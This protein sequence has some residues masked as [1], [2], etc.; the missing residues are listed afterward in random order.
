[1]SK[2]FGQDSDGGEITLDNFR[3]DFGCESLVVAQIFKHHVWPLFLAIFMKAGCTAP[4][5]GVVSILGEPYMLD[6]NHFSFVSAMAPGFLRAIK[7]QGCSRPIL[8]QCLLY[9]Q[10]SCLSQEKGKWPP[11][12]RKLRNTSTAFSKIR[13]AFFD[14]GDFLSPEMLELTSQ[15]PPSRN[16][17][18][19]WCFL[20]KSA[21]VEEVRGFAFTGGSTM[22]WTTSTTS[23]DTGSPGTARL[24]LRS[25]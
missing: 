12:S 23:W 7:F 11:R 16:C 14:I 4:T 21:A 22:R 18:L 13:S 17:L 25:V 15:D 20:L 1:M 8:P 6:L 2:A 5:I 19:R 10:P 24:P 3:D 9:L